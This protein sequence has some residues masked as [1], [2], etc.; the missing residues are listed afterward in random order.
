MR[1]IEETAMSATP[2]S[3]EE[4]LER[5]ERLGECPRCRRPVPL[6]AEAVRYSRQWF[7][8]RCALE[9]QASTD[10]PAGAFPHNGH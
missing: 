3:P 1:G 4:A 5:I 9:Q 7:H 10:T 2:V 6:G 8:L